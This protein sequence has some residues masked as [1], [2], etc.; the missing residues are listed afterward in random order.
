VADLDD[1]SK[2]LMSAEAGDVIFKEQDAGA[3]MYIIRNGQ[4]ELL[5]QHGGSERQILLLEAGDFFGEMSLL[6]GEPREVSA[7]AVGPVE[8]LRIDATTFDR[9]VQ[10]APEIP[11]R[12]LRKLC[13]RLREYQEHDARAA[14]IA[15]GPLPS[16]SGSMKAAPPVAPEP[17]PEPPPP[18]EEAEPEQTIGVAVLV[19][20]TSRKMFELAVGESTIGRVDRLTGF[21]PDVDLSSLDTQR[22]LSRRHAKIVHRGADYFVHEE[23]GTRNGTFVNGKRVQTGVDVKLTTG[24]RVR[25]GMIETVF[26]IR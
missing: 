14:A 8:L 11:V 24:D 9:I 6:E 5:K 22:T 26:E 2:F 25:F 23:I 16:V 12:M 13:K 21:S 15:M 18:A 19:D 17:E 7:R 3:D 10:E 4:I 1:L 20:P